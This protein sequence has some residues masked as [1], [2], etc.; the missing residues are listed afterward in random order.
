LPSLSVAVGAK[1][2]ACRGTPGSIHEYAYPDPKTKDTN[3]KPSTKPAATR[4][5]L[6]LRA[7]SAS[8][9]RQRADDRRLTQRLLGEHRADAVE[10]HDSGLD[11]EGGT[12]RL[13]GDEHEGVVA[14]IGNG[15]ASL[16]KPYESAS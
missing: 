5:A 2:R 7:P 6:R 14:E 16:R 9:R 15:E 3:S 4:V 1:I 11:E 13:V 8:A 12:E 10:Q